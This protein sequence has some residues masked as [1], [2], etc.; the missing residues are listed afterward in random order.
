MIQSCVLALDSVVRSA[1]GALRYR[2]SKDIEVARS[3]GASGLSMS[4][5][6]SRG[7]W[8]VN[9]LIFGGLAAEHLALASDPYPRNPAAAFSGLSV[10]LAAPAR[11]GI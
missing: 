5:A 8:S 4:L 6:M 7:R 9:A 3:G 11:R 1:R 10:A 2:F